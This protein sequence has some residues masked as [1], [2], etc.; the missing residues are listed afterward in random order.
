LKTRLFAASVL[1]ALTV[2]PVAVVTGLWASHEARMAAYQRDQALLNLGKDISR[3]LRQQRDAL[4]DDMRVDA[5]NAV[6]VEALESPVG[7]APL[8]VT[9]AL[10]LVADRDAVNMV[11]V[12][13]IDLQGRNRADTVPQAVGQQESAEAYFRSATDQPFPH[14]AG[15]PVLQPNG[16][17]RVV[18]VSPVRHGLRPLGYL[19]VRMD[20]GRIGQ[21]LQE[22]LS[23]TRDIQGVIAD[24][25]GR[26]HAWT[27]P[28]LSRDAPLPTGALPAEGVAAD[29]FWRGQALRGVVQRV[30]ELH[31]SVWI[32]ETALV[33]GALGAGWAEFWLLFM[34]ALCV[35]GVLTAWSIAVRLAR[36]IAAL[37]RAAEA[38][39]EG[40][41]GSRAPQ[42]GTE[43]LRR[44]SDSFNAMGEKLGANLQALSR[45]LDQRQRAER[46][47]LESQTQLRTMNQELEAQ[48]RE[49]TADL[50]S[51]KEAA[52][53][54]S[55]AKSAFL[56]NI[57]HE[58]RTPMNAIIGLGRALATESEHASQRARLAKVDH[59]AHHLMGLIN[60][61]LDLSR[62]EA[63]KLVLEEVDFAPRDLVAHIGGIV[64][65]LAAD[66]GITLHTEVDAALP[67]RLHGD[68]RRLSQ[69]LLNL[70]GNA[71]KFTASGEVRLKA[72]AVSA[73]SEFGGAVRVR[74]EVTD[75]GIGLSDA[76]QARVFE[77]FEQADVSITRRFGGTG[78]GLT[79]C[80]DL[81]LMM[82][83]SIGVQSRLG[84]GS[85]FWVELPF[86]LATTVWPSG[87]SAAAGSPQWSGRRALI[88]DDN[89]V[90]I[91]V[92]AL[93]LAAHGIGC[94][95]AA[96]GQAAVELASQHLYDLIL[97]DLHMPVMDGLQATR[98]I[99][100]QRLNRDAPILAM[101]A[102][103]YEE[104]RERCHA[105]GMNAHLGKPIDADELVRVLNAWLGQPTET[106]EA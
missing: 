44:L 20:T 95:S 93:M 49:R 60:D 86:G 22:M 100:Q 43:E 106:L 76:Q 94:D 68:E 29:F 66:K 92:M 64:E 30:P 11:S 71:I 77:A 27:D 31:F 65:L 73:V 17:S 46:A 12:G 57:S 63:G 62:I 80:R 54:A 41:L 52:E 10:A 72:H 42:G 14:V 55:R 79:I 23:L 39:A 18:M 83:G 36:P 53:A 3:V 51:A 48:V 82:K 58:I 40:D 91:E 15:E 101:T 104:D 7:V 8:S 78:L 28:L 99:R 25:Q 32:Y 50:A 19:R 37:S 59:A 5:A 56:A 61:V 16:R 98:L 103:V 87:P 90:N 97:M 67:E 96:D 26:L 70:L 81:S 35:L 13:L 102:N 84:E 69:I 45:E 9:R 33:H 85:T 75:T 38:M 105:A 1:F 47:L 6:L 24:D 4:L 88:V 74:F 34:A 89:P 21:T 2:L